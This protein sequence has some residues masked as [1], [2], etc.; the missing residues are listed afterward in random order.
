MFTTYPHKFITLPRPPKP[1]G[2]DGFDLSIAGAPSLLKFFIGCGLCA[3]RGQWRDSLWA[4][5][6]IMEQ[7]CNQT[8]NSTWRRTK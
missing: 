8:E 5:E 6:R 1:G 7:R 2:S 4:T 3:N